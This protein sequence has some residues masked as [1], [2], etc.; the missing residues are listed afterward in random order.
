MQFTTL[1]LERPEGTVLLRGIAAQVEQAASE[2]GNAAGWK[3]H[4]PMTCSGSIRHREC[5]RLRFSGAMCS[6]TGNFWTRRQESW[7]SIA[8]RGWWRRS[9]TTTRSCFASAWWAGRPHNE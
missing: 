3:A 8:S 4:A 5:R 9:T 2:E 7:R 1:R 6:S